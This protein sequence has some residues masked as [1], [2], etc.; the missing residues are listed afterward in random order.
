M[1]R[2]RQPLGGATSSGHGEADRAWLERHP[3]SLTLRHLDCGSCNG[4]EQQLI[5]LTNP[6]YDMEK[7]GIAFEA[8]PRHA[9]LLAMTGVFTRGLAEAARLT[10]KAMPE[11][12]IVAVGNC[13][14]YGGPF[15]DSYQFKDSY[16]VQR[17]RPAK[18]QP[19]S[20]DVG[21]LGR[22]AEESRVVLK[23]EDCPPTPRKILEELAGYVRRRGR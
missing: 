6:L 17:E 14:I 13:A 20:D 1:T 8:S 10:L 21:A 3:A 12:G 22:M 2:S 4:C 9:V 19:K 16:A 11:Q 23:I 7:Y 15:K 18:F 5:A